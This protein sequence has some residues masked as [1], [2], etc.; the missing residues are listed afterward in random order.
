MKKAIT[1]LIA[2]VVLP[3]VSAGWPVQGQEATSPS[4]EWEIRLMPYVWMLGLD[5]DATVSGLSGSVD[6]TFGDVLD[7]LDMTAM[8]RLEAWKGKW[9][10]TFD[11]LYLDLGA[12]GSFQGT[13]GATTFSLD[14]DIRLGLADFGL[15]YRLFEQSFGENNEQKLTF[16]PY[17][18]LRYVYLK[19]KMDLNVA[20]AGIGA[21]GDNLGGSEDWIEPFV[22]GRIRWDLNDRL[23][24]DFRGDAGGFG[25]HDAS[26]L[27]W[28][29]A[30]G[31]DYKLTET[32]SLNAGY[33]I[34]DLDYSH[35]SGSDEFGLDL[36]ATG[37]YTGMTILF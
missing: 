21:A 22:G 34:L 29:M 32:T 10:V 18:G 15:A 2:I 17:G 24:L 9:G 25:M 12:D 6:L 7:N 20:I 8:G 16:E 4:D 27:L 11:G 14:A 1:Y 33:R 35:G 37:P 36:Q 19:Q 5:A 13:R 26:D 31:V 3:V 23:A 30:C 28:Q